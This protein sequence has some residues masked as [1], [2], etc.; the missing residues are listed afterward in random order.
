MSLRYAEF[1]VAPSS[2]S[3][4]DVNKKDTQPPQPENRITRARPH[5]FKA[6]HFQII[7]EFPSLLPTAPSS[8]VAMQT[9]G[10]F[11]RSLHTILKPSRSW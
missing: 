2:I 3:I 10:E 4:S 1:T 9:D 5:D 8:P 6:L 11:H 7:G